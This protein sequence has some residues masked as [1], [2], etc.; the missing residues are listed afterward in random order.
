MNTIFPTHK[1]VLTDTHL[2]IPTDVILIHK[3]AP[4]LT[5]V[6]WLYLLYNALQDKTLLNKC[7]K[8]RQTR[9]R[10]KNSLKKKGY[11]DG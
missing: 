4:R 5:A 3:T 10:I 6:E 1:P 9:W 8:S 2:E 11:I 7:F